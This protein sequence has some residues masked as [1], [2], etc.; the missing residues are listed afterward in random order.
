MCG[1]SRL[2]HAQLRRRET[3]VALCP[4]REAQSCSSACP[5]FDL[6]NKRVLIVGGIARMESLYRKLVEGNGGI[7][8]YHEGHMK[9]GAR[10]LENSLQRADLVLCPVNCNSHGA[11]SLVKQL[12]KKHNKLVC[13]MSNFSLSAISR[14]I[15]TQGGEAAQRTAA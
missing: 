8:D 6:C 15:E 1:E 10:Q 13:M 9:G 12:G 4:F 5:S 11:C 14:V 2:R 7:L 3:G